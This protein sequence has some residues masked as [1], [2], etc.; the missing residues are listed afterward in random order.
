MTSN[1]NFVNHPDVTVEGRGKFRN[2][3]GWVKH[4]LRRKY[5]VTE[6]D[7]DS[8]LNSS[9][10]VIYTFGTCE[11]PHWWGGFN[12]SLLDSRLLE[13]VRNRTAFIHYDQSLEAFDL[14]NYYQG[15]HTGFETYN[16]PPEQFIVSTSNLYE[17]TLYEQWCASNNVSERMK[18]VCL[19]FFAQASINYHFYGNSEANEITTAEQQQHTSRHLFNS[20]NRV[21]RDHRVA[22]VSMMDYYGLV[23]TNRVSHNVFPGHFRNTINTPT[24]NSHPAFSDIT[25]IKS[26]LPLVLDTDQFQVNTAH[27]FFKDI[28]LTTWVSVI[29][30]TAY[31]EPDTIFFSEKIFKPIRARHPFILVGTPGILS[32]FKKLGFKTFDAWWDESYD[33]ITDP[34]ARLDAV[35]KLLIQLSSISQEQWVTIYKEMEA[36]LNYNFNVLTKTNWTASITGQQYG[37]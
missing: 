35:C 8:A 23:D 22:L 31:S 30:E 17:Q 24:F 26:K 27:H 18:L 19:P 11:G 15:Y 32:E 16:L 37:F 33:T 25:K 4:A 13:R 5:N 6:L 7:L 34:V 12:A 21:L 14:I 10:T 3:Q 9:D 36:H 29:T 28:Y 20:L 2:P 1:L